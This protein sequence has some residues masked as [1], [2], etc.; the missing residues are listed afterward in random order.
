[1]IAA[2]IE[3]PAGGLSRVAAPAAAAVLAAVTALAPSAFA[4]QTRRF[5]LDTPRTLA[6]G[7]AAG[8]A[9]AADGSLHPLQPLSPVAS[10][11][12]PL[13]LAL[14]VAPDGT[15]WVGTGHPA[16]VYHVSG[17]KKELVA[18]V[19]ADQVTAL[20]LDPSGALWVSTAVPAALY[21]LQPGAKALAEVSKLAEGNIWDLAWFRGALVAA[22][23]NP[24]RLLRL[25][26]KG[27]ELAAEVQDLHARCLAVSGD[28]L[29]IGTSGKGRVLR[30]TGDGPPGVLYD[31]SFTEI[32]ALAVA[33]DGTV[34]AAALT[35]DPTLGKPPKAESDGGAT[36]TVVAGDQTPPPSTDKGTATSEIL[37]ILPVGAAT[38][39]YRFSKQLAGAL[40]WGDG[41]LVIGTGLEG[42]LWQLVEGAAAQLD[43]VDAAQVVRLADG[44]RRARRTARSP[45]RRSTPRSRHTGARS[46]CWPTSPQGRNARSGSAREPPPS[47]TTR[48]ARGR[49]RSRAALAR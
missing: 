10:F 23:G 21:R 25:G 9:V 11:E 40:A 43:T 35:G 31:S 41:G 7:R 29:I 14:A 39:A 22:A 38:S 26:A 49:R 13:G 17:G 46:A 27:L 5:T 4:G 3:R 2:R 30:W 36:V 45:R 16:R 19:A 34:W 32:A 8:I 18:E 20:L 12:E 1:M 24:G 42:E 37:R 33:P 47:P 28:D 48:G 15:A 44:G 6:D